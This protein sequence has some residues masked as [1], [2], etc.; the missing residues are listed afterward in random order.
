MT[1]NDRSPRARPTVRLLHT[2]D[3][4]LGM[5]RGPT[6]RAHRPFCLCALLTV[7][8]EAGRIGCDALLIVGDLFD[9]PRVAMADLRAT[10]AVLA[11]AALP[12]VILPGNHDALDDQSP[13]RRVDF[14]AL[15]ADVRVL[16]DV[17]G[18]SIDLVDGALHVWGRP[19]VHHTPMFRPLAGVALRPATGWFVAAAHG[20][21]TPDG[22][23][24]QR[25]V[26][27][28]S[29]ITP[30]D[31]EESNADYVALGHWDTPTSVGGPDLPAWYS[32]CP[33]DGS[34]PGR[35]LLVTLDDASP[36]RIEQR[37]LRLPEDGCAAAT[38]QLPTARRQA[39]HMIEDRR[40]R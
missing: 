24:P 5:S 11:V 3:L 31:I 9:H 10:A 13:Y 35:A 33:I 27:R 22:L 12:C 15:A 6:D 36:P 38:E 40:H 17:A 20:H 37:L 14:A 16:T 4:H 34:Q 18:S 7:T 25:T 2:S 26:V 39:D 32:G 19:T 30:T 1:V 28:S 21:F 8:A 29:P 23:D